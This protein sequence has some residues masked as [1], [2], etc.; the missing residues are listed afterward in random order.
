MFILLFILIGTCYC[1]QLKN[2]THVNNNFIV[3]ELNFIETTNSYLKETA[4]NFIGHVVCINSREIQIKPPPPRISTNKI[5]L[6]YSSDFDVLIKHIKVVEN[7]PNTITCN[8]IFE[9]IYG[10]NFADDVYF[11]ADAKTCFKAQHLL[12]NNLIATATFKTNKLENLQTLVETYFPD[13]LFY[14]QG[15]TISSCEGDVFACKYAIKFDKP[16]KTFDIKNGNEIFIGASNEIYRCKFDIN[17]KY[18]CTLYSKF[19]QNV[20]SIKLF[21]HNLWVITDNN[22]YKCSLSPNSCEKWNWSREKMYHMDLDTE[23]VY[24]GKEEGKMWKCPMQNKDSCDT[25]NTFGSAI[26]DINVKEDNILAITEG[27]TLQSCPVYKRNAC[28]K[29][30][31]LKN[32]INK[33]SLSFNDTKIFLADN[34]NIYIRS[35]WNSNDEKIVTL[36]EKITDMYYSE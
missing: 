30:Q 31:D 36:H 33:I 22:I 16:I 11:S 2:I 25:I 6:K 14:S 19:D 20:N 21:R 29:L 1:C 12:K 17:N 26:I 15:T 4:R 35:Y 28:T 23:N 7:I 18:M 27:H 3:T 8:I 5:N 9:N 13:T 24:V 32:K 10:D 34:N